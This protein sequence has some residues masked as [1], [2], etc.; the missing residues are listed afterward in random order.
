MVF[1]TQPC[2]AANAIAGLIPRLPDRPGCDF[3]VPAGA[4]NPV[5]RSFAYRRPKRTTTGVGSPR[6]GSRPSVAVG[7]SR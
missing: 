5:G 1:L 7:A 4:R 6:S 3:G 2:S